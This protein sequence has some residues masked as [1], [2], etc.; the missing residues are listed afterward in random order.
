MKTRNGFTLVLLCYMLTWVVLVVF[1]PVDHLPFK[2]RQFEK[3]TVGE[4]LQSAF[5][6]EITEPRSV[7]Q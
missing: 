6:R 2:R 5:E 1:T 4:T 3:E 7:F